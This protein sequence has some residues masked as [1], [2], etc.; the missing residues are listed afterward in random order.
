MQYNLSDELVSG[1]MHFEGLSLKPYRCPAGRLTIGYGHVLTQPEVGQLRSITQAQAEQLLRNDLQA[2]AVHVARLL[3][4][5][6]EVQHQFDAMTSWT[7]NLGVG[8]L[9]RST[10][11][12]CHNAGDYD[13]AA[14]QISR[15]VYIHVDG[16][17]VVLDGLKRRR[18]WERAV[19]E[20]AAYAIPT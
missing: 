2:Y 12:R 20:R 17:P 19:Y 9:D 13:D 10:L 7:Y 15:W 4:G 18:K 1:V 8:A 16:K 5:I 11:R 6:Q 14:K 3:P